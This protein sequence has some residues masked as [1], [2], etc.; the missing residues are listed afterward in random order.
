MANAARAHP[1]GHAGAH[2]LTVGC[3]HENGHGESSVA[4]L[5]CAYSRLARHDIHIHLESFNR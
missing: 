2:R 4:E 5:V 3:D 1:L